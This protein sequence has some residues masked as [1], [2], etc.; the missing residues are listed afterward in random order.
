MEGDTLLNVLVEATG[1]P[2]AW[3]ESELRGLM[4]KRGLS[5]E[6]MT[7]ES[8]REI[9]AEFMQDVLLAAKEQLKEA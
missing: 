5:P 2:K 7:L 8:M 4:T 3:V 1:L 6:T 9:L